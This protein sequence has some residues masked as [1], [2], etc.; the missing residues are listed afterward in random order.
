VGSAQRAFTEVKKD[1]ETSLSKLQGAN[2]PASRRSLLREM[3]LLL[4]E[5]DRVVSVADPRPL[6]RS[7]AQTAQ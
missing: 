7:S 5:A 6:I 3:K 4:E 1:L 2:E